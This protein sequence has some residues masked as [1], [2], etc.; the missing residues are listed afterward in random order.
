M[1]LPIIPWCC[2][3]SYMNSEAFKKFKTDDPHH[4]IKQTLLSDFDLQATQQYDLWSPNELNT[5]TFDLQMISTLWPLI[6]KWTP[7]YDLWSPNELNILI[8]DLQM[9]STLWPLIHTMTSGHPPCCRSSDIR[10]PGTTAG[11]SSLLVSP[12][13]DSPPRPSSSAKRTQ[14]PC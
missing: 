5:M 12:P 6:S 8:F 14:T 3:P 4:S 11:S 13:P 2:I 10:P 7:H 9:I 1:S